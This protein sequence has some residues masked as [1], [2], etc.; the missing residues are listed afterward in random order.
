LYNLRNENYGTGN[1]IAPEIHELII[2]AER[3]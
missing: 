3:A 1:I 2:E